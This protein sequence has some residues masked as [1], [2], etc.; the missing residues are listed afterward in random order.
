MRSFIRFW[1]TSQFLRIFW[2]KEAFLLDLFPAFEDTGFVGKFSLFDIFP[3]SF[4]K[5]IEFP[6]NLINF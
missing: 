5:I 2:E 6:E 4:N 3:L 1:P